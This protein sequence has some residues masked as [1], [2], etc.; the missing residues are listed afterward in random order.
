MLVAMLDCPWS[1]WAPTAADF[2]EASLCAWIRQPANTWSNIGFVVGAGVLFWLTRREGWKHLRMLAYISLLTGLGSAFF[3][4]TET[5]VGLAGDYLGMYLGAAFM[6]TVCLRRWGASA[7]VGVVF[8]WG[9]TA[10]T[11][12]SLLVDTSWARLIYAVAGALCA[13]SDTTLLVRD[14]K[15]MVFRWYIV[16]WIAFLLA[17]VVWVKDL[18]GSWCDPD[19]HFINGHAGWHLLNAVAIAVS[20]AYYEQFDVLREQKNGA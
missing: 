10:L 19:N 14:R 18:D 17:G 5:R 2:C 6:L 9:F 7:R 15:T 20:A 3:H 4:A 8:F 12:S 13:I 1:T 11:M 16:M